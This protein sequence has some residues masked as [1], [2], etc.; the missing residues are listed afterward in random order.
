M[1]RFRSESPRPCTMFCFTL[2]HHAL[3]NYVTNTFLLVSSSYEV[4]NYCVLFTVK[5]KKENKNLQQRNWSGCRNHSHLL[6]M[7]R[8]II[9][10]LLSVFHASVLLLSMNLVITLSSRCGSTRR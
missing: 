4:N 1:P 10:K 9:N 8:S 7:F 6:T 3:M 2:M 5:A